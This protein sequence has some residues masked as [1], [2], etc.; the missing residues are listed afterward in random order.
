MMLMI[1][2]LADAAGPVLPTHTA[3]IRPVLI[4]FLILFLLALIIGPIVR[5]RTPREVSSPHTGE[6]G[7]PEDPPRRLSH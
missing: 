5:A 7:V 6:P 4:A 3:W 2:L 1:Y